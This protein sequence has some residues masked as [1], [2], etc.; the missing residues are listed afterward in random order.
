MT[1][2]VNIWLRLRGDLQSDVIDRL[3]WDTPTQGPYSGPITEREC[4]LFG[5]MADRKS[6]QPPFLQPTIEG[7]PWVLWSLSLPHS[8]EY[9]TAEL[10]QLTADQVGKVVV[11]GAWHRD[12]TQYVTSSTPASPIYPISTASLL[13]FMPPVYDV[14]DDEFSPATELVDVNLLAG[15]SP[16]SFA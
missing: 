5:T 2:F 4:Y 1:E 16:R 11:E 14:D 10:D 8:I 13:R 6:A 7:N 3:Q 15:Q 12:G 9:V